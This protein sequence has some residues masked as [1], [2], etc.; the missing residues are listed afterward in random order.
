MKTISINNGHST[1]TVQEAL[2]AVS[3]D[4]IANVMD[5]DTREQVH[6]ELAPCTDEEFLERYLEIAPYDIVIG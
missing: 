1:C 3:I 6:A 5:D 2:A 4:V